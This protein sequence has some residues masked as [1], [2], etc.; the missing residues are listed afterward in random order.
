MVRSREQKSNDFG[1]MTRDMVI[2]GK[3]LVATSMGLCEESQALLAQARLQR[4]RFA[5]I[6]R[7]KDNRKK[8][9]VEVSEEAGSDRSYP[10]V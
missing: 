4:N 6:R 3:Q 7:Q 2:W 9:L 10:M 5:K 1:V 8:E